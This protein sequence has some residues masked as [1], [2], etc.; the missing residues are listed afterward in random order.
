MSTSSPN[1]VLIMTDQHRYD[2]LGIHGHPHVM[3]PHLDHFAAQGIDCSR[4]YSDCPTCIPARHCLLTGCHPSTTGV[5]GFD[6]TA[7]IHR[8]TLPD[9]LRRAGYQTVS[10]G[11]SMHQHPEH[12][13]YGFEIRMENPYQDRY[14]RIQQEFRP[15]DQGIFG[16]HPHINGH[17]LGPNSHIARPWPFA[18][19]FHQ[20]NWAVNKA[21]EFLD[22]RDRDAPFFL[23]L[24]FVA[25][26]PPL[27]PPR[28]YYQRYVDQDLDDPVVGDWV[29]DPP[30]LHGM[31][32]GYHAQRI[33]GQ[34]NQLCR[35]GYY[36]LINHVD[37]QLNIFLTRLAM[38]SEPVY[39]VFTSDH[40]EM[41]GDH[42]CFRKAVGLEGSAH[43]PLMMTGPDLES[44]TTLDT[45]VTLADLMPT[46][47]DWAGVEPI[48][49]MDGTS[50]NEYRTGGMISRDWIHGEHAPAGSPGHH[51][52]VDQRH[53]YIWETENGRE[54]LFDLKADPG[55]CHNLVDIPDHQE[56]LTQMRGL[57]AKRLQDRPEGFSDGECLIPGRPHTNRIPTNTP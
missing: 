37:D 12:R 54:L 23:S 52:L 42:H 56:T 45:P 22:H 53:K 30:P 34:R 16:N 38:E 20:T 26:H 33:E 39:V 8:P 31:E 32:P 7:E 19:E 28:D 43:V 17:G 15:S 35:A 13:R 3:T 25:P 2:C 24:G 57:L 47:L 4:A 41:L 10:V 40:G 48:G 27:I 36:G 50:L 49:E 9:T 44:G 55:E 14:S 5:V 46:F 29:E 1:L 11:R 6:T 51:Y 18:E 21:V